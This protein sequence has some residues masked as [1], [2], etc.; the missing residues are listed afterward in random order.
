MKKLLALLLAMAMVLSLAA[1][2]GSDTPAAE[3]PQADAPQAE[4]LAAY[5]DELDVAITANPPTLDVH[6]SNSNIVGGIGS[7]IYE[8][9]FAMNQENVPTPVLAESYEISEDGTVYTIKIRQGIKFHNGQEMTA[10]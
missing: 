2:G 1:C 7:H 4:A 6:F 8:P 9:L 3:E 10:C 5:K